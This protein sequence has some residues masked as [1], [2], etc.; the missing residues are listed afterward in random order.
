MLHPAGDDRK[1]A[2]GRGVRQS[3]R[4][5]AKEETTPAFCA[6]SN[7]DFRDAESEAGQCVDLKFDQ[8]IQ[9][10]KFCTNHGELE[11]KLKPL[12]AGMR[13]VLRCFGV[14]Q[15][16]SFEKWVELQET[17]RTA[18]PPIPVRPFVERILIPAYTDAARLLYQFVTADGTADLTVVWDNAPRALAFHALMVNPNLW[19]PHTSSAGQENQSPSQRGGAMRNQRRTGRGG[20]G[21]G[22]GGK[23][24]RPFYQSGFNQGGPQNP[25]V[26]QDPRKESDPK[27]VAFQQLVSDKLGA[28]LPRE[29]RPCGVKAVYGRC[30]DPECNRPHYVPHWFNRQAFLAEQSK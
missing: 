4:M 10:V 16:N 7:G 21:R 27:L 23:G 2:L 13:W 5:A 24:A 19:N 18:E 8:L 25:K 12:Q 29:A 3:F 20:R 28:D 6:A 1:R 15:L 9:S 30:N 11:R 22:T 14:E 17:G 26:R